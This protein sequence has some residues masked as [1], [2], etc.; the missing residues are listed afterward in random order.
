MYLAESMVHLHNIARCLSCCGRTTM[1]KLFFNDVVSAQSAGAST[2]VRGGI[3]AVQLFSCSTALPTLVPV[4]QF[5]P[6]AQKGSN[7]GL[8]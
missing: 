4:R 1:S 2:H 3:T 6:P 5:G 8:G 7:K